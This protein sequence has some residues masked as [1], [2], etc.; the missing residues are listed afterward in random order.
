VSFWHRSK[1]FVGLI[2]LPLA[3]TP[4]VPSTAP[5]ARDFK[6]KLPVSAFVENRGQFDPAARF[7]FKMPNGTLWVTKKGLVFDIPGSSPVHVGTSGPLQTADG[8]Q[9][10]LVFSEDYVGADVDHIECFVRSPGVYNFLSKDHIDSIVGIPACSGIVA[11]DIWPGIDLKLYARHSGIEQEFLIHRGA[12]PAQILISYHGVDKV[13]TEDGTLLV[14]TAVGQLTEGKLAVYQDIQGSRIPIN[15][16]FKLLNGNSFSF[17]LNAYNPEYDTVVDPPLLFSTY[18]GGDGPE[19]TNGV[20]VDPTGAIY[21]VGTTNSATFPTNIG[22]YIHSPNSGS[23]V[24]ITKLNPTGTAL[25]Y[26]TYIN[27]PT[28][29]WDGYYGQSIAVDKAG[30]VYIAG[31]ASVQASAYPSTA[32]AFQGCGGGSTLFLSKLNASADSLLYSTCFSGDLNGVTTYVSR[33][34]PITADDTGHVFWAGVT[35]CSIPTTTKRVPVY[36]SRRCKCFLC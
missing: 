13:R 6:P 33:K 17:D 2:L 11:H 9:Q 1:L 16:R 26:S 32:T 28:S 27:S 12:D 15:A 31:I 18:L 10:G 29:W 23:A 8:A 5:A 30:Q 22:L 20:A 7:E 24:F 25:V 19:Q 36:V 3:A 21:V 4:E 35:S 34:F 14:D